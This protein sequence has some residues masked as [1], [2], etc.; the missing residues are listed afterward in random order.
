MSAPKPFRGLVDSWMAYIER[1]RGMAVLVLGGAFLALG[2]T[3]TIVHRPPLLS[4]LVDGI[5]GRFLSLFSQP[6]KLGRFFLGP[7]G[8][9]PRIMELEL[10]LATLRRADREN[11]RLRAMLGYAP[12]AGFQTVPGRVIGLDLDP[13]RGLA[14]ISLGS[15]QGLRGGEAV[16]TVEGLIGVVDEVSGERS[17]VR[18]LRNEYTPVS[19][20]D[21]RSRSLGIVEW[22]PGAGRLRVGQ[23]PFQADVAVGDTLVSSGLGGVFPPNLPVGTV[24]EV[25]EPPERLLKEV[26]VRSFGA[27][28]RLEEVFVLLAWEGPVLSE[29][30]STVFG[31]AVDSLSGSTGEEPAENGFRERESAVPD[32]T[33]TAPGESGEP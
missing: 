15:A 10:E 23:V 9:S 5:T 20:R 24:A 11:A 21:V 27:F 2:T 12:P 25:R 13:L 19:V 18:L 29:D 7:H 8:G 30:E 16:M 26:F 17:R 1:R 32:P 3:T 14:W 22:D 33:E 6:L 4:P 28:D 31:G